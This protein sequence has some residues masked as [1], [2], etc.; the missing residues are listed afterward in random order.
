MKTVEQ[1]V[2][3]LVEALDKMGPEGS[4]KVREEFDKIW[5]W[6]AYDQ[7]KEWKQ[8]K[9]ML[10]QLGFKVTWGCYYG[11]AAYDL[12]TLVEWKDRVA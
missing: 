10:E 9:G 7:T 1:K 8:A 2:S 12:Y 4:V 6:G 11:S 5:T 3:E